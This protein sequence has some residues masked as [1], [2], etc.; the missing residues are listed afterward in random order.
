MTTKK[1]GAEEREVSPVSSELRVAG[2]RSQGRRRVRGGVCRGGRRRGG[3][4]RGCCTQCCS[5][6]GGRL[7]CGCSSSAAKAASSGLGEESRRSSVALAC[8]A[9]SSVGMRR[10]CGSDSGSGALARF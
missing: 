1:L 9:R 10:H 5:G 7:R 6:V 4:R 8:G 3:R 2:R